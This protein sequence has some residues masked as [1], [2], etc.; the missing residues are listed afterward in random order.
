M[1]LQRDT[2]QNSDAGQAVLLDPASLPTPWGPADS[3]RARQLRPGPGSDPA[4]VAQ[5]QRERLFAAMVASVAERGY[6]ATTLTHLVEIS[7]VS[8][9]SLYDLFANKDACFRAAIEAI[10]AGG[11]GELLGDESPDLSWKQRAYRRFDAYARLI[12][13]QPAAAKM[14]LSEAYVAGPAARAPVEDAIVVWEEAMAELLAESPE[15]AE[16]PS[17]MITLFAGSTLEMARDRLQKGRG[18]EVPDLIREAVEVLLAYRP[19]PEP[20]R[21]ATRPPKGAA[22]VITGPDHRERA[23]RA[24]AVV[25]AEQGYQNVGVS[26]VIKRASMSPATFYA[27]FSSKEDALIAAIESAGAQVVAATLPAFR[28]HADWPQ[29]VRAAIGALLN[30]LASRPALA[31]LL[32]VEVYAAGARALEARDEALKG[33]EAILA[34]GERQAFDAQG[35]SPSWV[36]AEGT[37]ALA[38]RRVREVGPES[39]PGMAPVLTYLTLAPFL[40]AERACAAANGSGQGRRSHSAVLQAMWEVARDVTLKRRVMANVS[41][42]GGTTLRRIAAELGEPTEVVAE[43]LRELEEEE[44][45]EAV[46]RP[47]GVGE[48]IYRSNMMVIEEEQWE[49]L[50]QGERER[51]SAQIGYLIASEIELAVSAKT[52]DRR[53]DRHLTRH[54]LQVDEAGWA[55]L[56]EIHGATLSATMQVQ[57]ECADRLRES[58]EPGVSVRSLQTLF[59]MP[60]L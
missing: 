41:I 6:A 24:L 40:G 4:E 12:A 38:F 9:R 11:L 22:E 58:G 54:E 49:R 29:G 44:L 60:D 59:E 53:T 43:H 15:H 7:G 25:A 26:E 37:Y 56:R 2:E 18:D 48:Q 10:L 27:N 39:L 13:D 5:N 32:A 33:L 50:S 17:E 47:G 30:F 36:I 46:E 1:E 19:P 23:L 35:S 16:M 28:R 8:R 34:P 21:M 42:G 45:I 31:R 20:L 51:I 3:L 57:R 14:C 55:K 52:Y